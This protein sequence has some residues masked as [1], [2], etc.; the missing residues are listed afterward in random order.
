MY[1]GFK[2]ALGLPL[3]Q[4][5][6]LQGISVKTVKAMISRIAAWTQVR[7]FPLYV[8]LMRIGLLL[9]YITHYSMF[10]LQVPQTCHLTLFPLQVATLVRIVCSSLL[11][12]PHTHT[13]TA[14]YI[15]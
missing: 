14:P 5:R 2:H 11:S 7:G 12:S 3:F 15:V 13:H 6:P 1:N 8:I 10:L 9:Y 4:K